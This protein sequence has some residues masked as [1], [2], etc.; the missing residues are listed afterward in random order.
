MQGHFA[1]CRVH[2]AGPCFQGNGA[3]LRSGAAVAPVYAEGHWPQALVPAVLV[4]RDANAA[5][6]SLVRFC[7]A[8][9]SMNVRAVQAQDAKSPQ[10]ER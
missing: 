3:V 9:A 7:D 1:T 5:R 6:L 2:R 10:L 4:G 8:L